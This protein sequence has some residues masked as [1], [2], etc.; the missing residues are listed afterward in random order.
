MELR[1][2]NGQ[3]QQPLSLCRED[4]QWTGFIRAWWK[5]FGLNT[6]WYLSAV[7]GVSCVSVFGLNTTWGMTA[8]S[9]LS[10]I[11]APKMEQKVLT[12]H[13]NLNELM[14]VYVCDKSVADSQLKSGPPTMFSDFCVLY[15]G[16]ATAKLYVRAHILAWKALGKE[17]TALQACVCVYLTSSLCVESDLSTVRW[18]HASDLWCTI[19]TSNYSLRRKSFTPRMKYVHPNPSHLFLL[20]SERIPGCSWVRNSDLQNQYHEKDNKPPHNVIKSL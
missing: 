8:T 4:G 2:E 12:Q 17:I 9:P 5:S 18:Q 10:E 14:I 13:W 15:L 6:E 11:K 7:G 16:K 1:E 20:K 19:S 3:Q